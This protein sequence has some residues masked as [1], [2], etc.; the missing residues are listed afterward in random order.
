MLSREE[1]NKLFSYQGKSGR[2]YWKVKPHPNANVDVG[3]PAGCLA[4]DGYIVI[5]Y[6]GRYYKAHRII[7]MYIYGYLPKYLDHKDGD[8]SN[9]RLSNLRV[10]TSQQNARNRKKS[11]KSLSSKYKGVHWV[12]SR[13]RWKAT[14]YIDGNVRQLGL[15]VTE[16]EAAVAYNNAATLWFKSYAVLNPV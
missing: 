8:K 11:T 3:D 2:L 9:N 13:N 12:K 1:I 14:I 15:Y 6:K 5:G 16:H 10:A 4:S 7:W